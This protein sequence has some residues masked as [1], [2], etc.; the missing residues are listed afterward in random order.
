M[1]CEAVSSEQIVKYKCSFKR[2][3]IYNFSREK[4]KNGF[5]PLSHVCFYAAVSRAVIRLSNFFSTVFFGPFLSPKM[6]L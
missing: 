6:F 4:T 3:Q 5:N 2:K 1:I